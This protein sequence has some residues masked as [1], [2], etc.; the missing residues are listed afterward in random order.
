MMPMKMISNRRLLEFDGMRD[1]G[2]GFT[3]RVTRRPE[4]DFL[5]TAVEAPQIDGAVG[6]TELRAANALQHRLDQWV[7][8]GG[9]LPGDA[10][11]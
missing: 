11:G 10:E 1:R 6:P 5:A 9:H 3:I 4:G 2:Q 7:V 8:D